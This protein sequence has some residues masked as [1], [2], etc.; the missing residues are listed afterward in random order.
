MK[1]KSVKRLE[2]IAAAIE[3]IANFTR[4]KTEADYLTDSMLRSAVLWQLVRVCEAVRSL[5]QNDTAVAQAI[6]DH[7][8]IIRF[9][10]LLIHEYHKVQHDYVWQYIQT[11]LPT[12]RN[13]V[14]ALLTARN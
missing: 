4:G 7:R 8:K 10:T 5:A 11:D 3:E 13:D 1:P 14:A 6:N 9:R 12:L 2:E